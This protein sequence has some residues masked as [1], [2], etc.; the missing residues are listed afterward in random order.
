MKFFKTVKSVSVTHHFQKIQVI[1]T[2]PISCILPYSPL[3]LPQGLDHKPLLCTC[4]SAPVRLSALPCRQQTF[5]SISL[6]PNF[7]RGSEL[8][9]PVPIRYF[10]LG[11]TQ[12]LNLSI[13]NS[14]ASSSFKTSSWA[15]SAYNC[16][17]YHHYYFL[18][19]VIRHLVSMSNNGNI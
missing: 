10:H 13:F 7:S 4:V 15:T 6:S 11:F 3:L 8:I 9:F 18:L 2:K 1:F 19:T 14:D 5:R 17:Q 12:Y 16:Q